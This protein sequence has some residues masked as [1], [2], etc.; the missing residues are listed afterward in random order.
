MVLPPQ[1]LERYFAKGKKVSL[2]THIIA[3][4]EFTSESGT[5]LSSPVYY[6]AAG[7]TAVQTTFEKA[8]KNPKTSEK[9]NALLPRDKSPWRFMNYDQSDLVLDHAK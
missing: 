2:N 4:A 7:K 9:E 5:A 1:F 8:L 3:K 6:S